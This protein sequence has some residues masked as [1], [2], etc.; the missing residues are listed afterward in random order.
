MY[1]I[2]TKKTNFDLYYGIMLLYLKS[3]G[4]VILFSDMYKN[5]TG[6]VLHMYIYK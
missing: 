4:H 6:S 3:A 1:K 2:F 5:I